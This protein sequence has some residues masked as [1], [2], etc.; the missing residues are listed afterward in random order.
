MLE[1]APDPRIKE[2]EDWY[3]QLRE[4]QEIID[5]IN[6]RYT[7]K[8]LIEMG[9]IDVEMEYGSFIAGC[10]PESYP[11]NSNIFKKMIEAITVEEAIDMLFVSDAELI[12]E[13]QTGDLEI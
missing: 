11:E 10:S 5:K 6:E 12:L 13:A 4:D 8:D 9:F 7:T 3:D 2:Q 1:F